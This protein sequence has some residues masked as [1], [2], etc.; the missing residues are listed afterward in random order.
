MW[1]FEYILYFR[2]T[3]SCMYQRP[4]LLFFKY[5]RWKFGL[6]FLNTGNLCKNYCNIGFRENCIYSPKTLNKSDDNIG[7]LVPLFKA[8]IL[9]TIGEDLSMAPA[10][11]RAAK[12]LRGVFCLHL[13]FYKVRINY[14]YNCPSF[15][16]L[17]GPIILQHFAFCP[18]VHYIL[19][20]EP[21]ICR[22]IGLRLR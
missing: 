2:I 9:T 10:H 19:F 4:M 11:G 3:K 7:S 5:F 17:K 18:T 21:Y 1:T 13:K 15:V 12:S 22:N 6:F 20:I 14:F 8:G 16:N